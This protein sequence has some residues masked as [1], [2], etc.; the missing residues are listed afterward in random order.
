MARQTQITATTTEYRKRAARIIAAKLGY[1]DLSAYLNALLER[2]IESYFTTEELNELFEV[3]AAEHN[4]AEGVAP[5]AKQRK[6]R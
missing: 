1:P 6:A 2:E 5:P 3:R 4:H